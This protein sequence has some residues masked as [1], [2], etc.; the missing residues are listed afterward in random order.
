[1]QID[2]T[3][4]KSYKRLKQKHNLKNDKNRKK[5]KFEDRFES[6]IC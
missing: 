3:F 1:M 2:H 6:E 4:L 5:M